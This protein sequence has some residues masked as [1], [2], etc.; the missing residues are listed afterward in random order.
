M[1]GATAVTVKVVS[2]RLPQL[3]SMVKTALNSEVAKAAHEIEAQ[4]KVNAPVRTGTLRRSIHTVIEQGGQRAVIGPSV[5]YGFYVEYGSRGRAPQ[6][7]MRPAA[8]AVLPRFA[9]GVKVAL[10]GLK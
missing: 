5:E 4:A 10:A 1:P 7:F 3:P 6:P 2:N 9:T 8:E